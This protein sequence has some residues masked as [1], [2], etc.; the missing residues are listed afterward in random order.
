MSELVTV[1]QRKRRAQAYHPNPEECQSVSD[2]TL[3]E[4]VT[5]AKAEQH[6]LRPC[7]WC[8]EGES[9]ETSGYDNSLYEAA[10]NYDPE[11]G[12]GVADD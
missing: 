11:Q 6:G 3:T 12:G 2:D 4:E 1:R 10:K 8:S 9:V 7:K 5:V